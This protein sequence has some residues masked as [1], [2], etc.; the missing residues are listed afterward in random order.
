[1]LSSEKDSTLV[2]CLTNVKNHFERT[3]RKPISIFQF[4]NIVPHGC[5][6]HPDIDDHMQ[7]AEQIIPFYQQLIGDNED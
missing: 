7:M 2:K 1:M 3:N 5:D 4:E 6:N